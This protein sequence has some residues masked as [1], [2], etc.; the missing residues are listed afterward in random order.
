MI[1]SKE[2][3]YDVK[4]GDVC[5]KADGS[6]T[7]NVLG[8]D[9]KVRGICKDIK[10]TVVHKEEANSNVV[11]RG[12]DARIHIVGKAKQGSIYIEAASLYKG[13]VSAA[14]EIEGEVRAEHK[15]YTFNAGNE[16]LF[17]LS[18]R[19]LSKEEAR[20]TIEDSFLEPCKC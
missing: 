12:K 18:T 8:G 10:L 6:I 5:I 1:I 16:L 11:V 3:T 9:V 13:D 20:K 17:Y 15:A 14:L 19:G 2:G 7:I 4:G